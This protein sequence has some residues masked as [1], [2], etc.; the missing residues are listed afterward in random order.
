MAIKLHAIQQ[1]TE[2]DNKEIPESKTIEMSKTL[3][4][5]YKEDS[6]WI[7]VSKSVSETLIAKPYEIPANDR[8][9]RVESSVLSYF[10]SE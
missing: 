1:N 3:I 10:I 9:V 2:T 8:F 6:R 4:I 5:E 7:F